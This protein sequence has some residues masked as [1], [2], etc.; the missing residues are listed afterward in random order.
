MK[1]LIDENIPFAE[2]AFAGFGKVELAA[3]REITDK[4]LKDVDILIV[5]SV[6]KVN[7]SLL[8]HT[9]VTF[10]GTT[11]IGYDHIDTTYLKSKK[12]SYAN[13]PG[14]NADSVAEY[15]IASL[16]KIAFEQNFKLNEKSIGIIGYG[17]IGTRVNRIAG[18]FGMHTIINDP[19]LQRET[20][21][22]I[23]A[24]YKEALQA[25]IITYHV[26][27]NINGID[28]TY[29]MLSGEHLKEFN[30]KKVIINSSRGSVI[31]ND[32]F[33]TYL[34]NHKNIVI[35]DVWENEPQI[36]S[37]LLK[38]VTIGSAHV[39]GY[40]LEG[41]INGTVM[42]YEALC[43]FL[44]INPGWK[45]ELPPVDNSIFEYPKGI[46]TEEALNRIIE[47]IYNIGED[48][49]KLRKIIDLDNNDRGRYFDYLR[50]NYRVRREFSNYSI[51]IDKYRD[52]EIKI[53]QAL[54]FKVISV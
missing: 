27:L 10:V 13:S 35:L 50:K 8:E 1:I 23:F 53:L 22:S 48:D 18:S 24:T 36:D 38:L 40:S 16:V 4:L 46:R 29:H 14:C 37:E 15:I 31:S 2:E 47:V 17:N 11:T 34:M 30:D 42:I 7:K 33:K 39:A 51:R 32:D 9:P 12:I 49:K 44:N 3:G 26:P 6:T 5:R 28:K 54:R 52:E 41:K 43:R 45:P 21:E 19:P 20:K 25:D